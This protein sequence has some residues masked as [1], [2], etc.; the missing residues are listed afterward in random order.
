MTSESRPLLAFGPAIV[1]ERKRKKGFPNLV[2]P[3]SSRQVSRIEPQ[4]RKLVATFEAQRAKMGVGIP[5]EVDPNLVIVFDLA[6][7]VK[8]FCNAINKI[9]GLE[10]LSEFVGDDTEPDDDFYLKDEEGNKTDKLVSHSLYLV[11][12]NMAAIEE[13]LQLF[14]KWKSDPKVTLDRG[15]Y[16]FKEMFQQ[17]VA[18]RHWGPQDRIQETGLYEEWKERLEVIGNSQSFVQVEVELW[19]RQDKIKQIKAEE[20]V[21]N[22]VSN[23]A[24]KVI[25]RA[26][27]PEINYHALLVELPIQ[28]VELF[29]AE[30]AESV[31]LLTV[32][33]IMF[34]S[35][36]RPMALGWQDN[37]SIADDDLIK[38]IA[39]NEGE[40]IQ[41][42]PRVALLDGLPVSN[43]G[44]LRGRL[45][46]D[47]PDDLENHYPVIKRQHGT[48]MAS[49]IIHG[50]L[51]KP[52]SPLDR[53]LY[54][55]PIMESVEGIGC[56]EQVISNVLFPDL[57]IRAVRR[58]MEGDGDSEAVA[59]SVRIINLSIGDPARVL[60]R[61]MSPGGRVLDWLAV[62]Y[63][64]LFIV[65]AGNHNEIPITI[66]VEALSN[67]ESARTAAVQATFNNSLLLGI[68]SPGDAIN[69]LTIGATH[70]DKADAIKVPDTVLDV[71]R[72][73]F[74]AHYSGRG[75]GIN[76][77]IKPDLYYM[78]GRV[79]Y[80]RP[81]ITPEQ[82]GNID[83]EIAD[84]SV[85]GPGVR[86]AVPSRGG[87]INGT[88]FCIGTSNAAALVTHEA[89]KLFDI[90]EEGNSENNL[91][92]ALYHPLLVRALLVHASSWGEWKKDLDLKEKNRKQLTPLLGYGCL[93]PSRLGFSARNRAMVIAG[94]SITK[95]QRHTYNLPLP[96]SLRSKAEWH[97]FTVTLAFAAPTVGTLNQYRGSKV[98]FEF[99]ENGL[100]TVDRSEAEYY[101]ARRGSLQHEIIE[102]T[103][104]MTFVEGDA[105]SIHVECMDDAQHLRKKEEIKYALVASVE[106]AE[107]TSTTI[108]DEVRMALR[109]RARDHIRGRVQ[110]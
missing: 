50:D 15:L 102:G 70:N 26:L 47:D 108:Y 109:T 101:A 78:G 107:Q 53:P 96:L 14:E 2:T 13:L 93:D 87:A 28:Q 44:A 75:P 27:I 71:N 33:E 85:V 69:V 21:R 59:P 89:S 24:G 40:R 74:P 52:D 81:V 66:P 104:A 3:N 29:L 46:I 1:G 45:I 30:G 16:K 7:S 20:I 58:I 100:E 91:P 9:E 49:L 105:F 4:F 80:K 79:V 90:L 67:I 88:K 76:R 39:L 10:F 31:Q 110:G 17:L 35:P 61:R 48:E 12:S 86:A 97:R 82:Q 62:N 94:G 106:T 51:N 103:R 19:Y 25:S 99:E 72:A 32:D 54:V 23:V 11:M 34:V 6:G 60:T 68:L 63:N 36:Y 41:G 57:L 77:S 43:H 5:D 65:S 64:L 73:N 37:D 83:L 98:Y 92:D 22:N 8:D 56:T 42:K 84:S 18:I 95:D 55:R 38:G